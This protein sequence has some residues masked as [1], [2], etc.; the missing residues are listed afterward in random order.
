MLTFLPWKLQF[1]AEGTFVSCRGNFRFLPR[2][3]S[4]PA[5]GTTVSKARKF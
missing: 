5:E 1:P 3:L 2:E 4:F